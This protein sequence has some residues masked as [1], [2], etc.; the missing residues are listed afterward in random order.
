MDRS[1]LI[2]DWNGIGIPDPGKPENPV[3]FSDETLRDGLQSPSITDP[4]IEDKIKIL[5]LINSLGIDYADIGLPMAGP[6]VVEAVTMLA[7]EIVNNKLAVKPSCAARTLVSDIVPI[8]EISQKVG[9]PLAVEMF[10]GSSN[11]RKYTEEWSLDNM[12][13]LTVESVRYAVAHQLPALYV[14]EDTTRAHPETIRQLYTAAIENGAT[15][16]YICD[17]VGHATPFGVWNLV[18][19]MKQIIADAG[20]PIKIGFHG[21]NDRGL[22]LVNAITALL[23]GADR[24]DGCSLGIGERSGNTP[25]DLLLVNLKILGWIDNDLTKLAEY[26]KTVAESCHAPLPDNYPVFGFDAFCTSTGV[27]AAAVMKALKK[28]SRD[29]LAD[30]IYSGVP[31]SMVGRKQ[32]I[33]IGPMSGKANVKYWM[34]QNNLPYEEHLVD[35][36]LEK[37]KQADHLLTDEEVCHLVSTAKQDAFISH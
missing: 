3:E 26:C 4:A 32:E 21:H 17:T 30:S 7:K 34:E 36:I 2:Y 12:I 37:A 1:E 13:R 27:H 15:C 20:V 16:V 23:A 31:A 35:L 24:V 28:E 29:W 25:L 9:I 8:V 14:T 10:I 6:R 33:R 5:H 22:S 11:I 19:F 18:H